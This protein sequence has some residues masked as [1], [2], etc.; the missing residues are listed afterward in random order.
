MQGTEEKVTLSLEE[1]SIPAGHRL[2]RLPGL[3]LVLGVA[4]L[5]LSLAWGRGDLP[6]LFGAYLVAWLFFLTLALGSLVFVLIQFATRAGW[7]VTVRR[8]AEHVMGTLPGLALLGLPLAWG[9]HDLYHW[10]HPEAVAADPVLQGKRP[11]LNE[12]F[13]L[14]RSLVYL[15]SWSAMAW[16]FRR[17]SLRQDELGQPDLTRRLQTL[18]PLGLIW[19]ALTLT[20]AS[21]DWIMSLDPHWYSTIFGVYVFAGAFLSAL[22]FLIVLALF[23]QSAGLVSH[24]VTT[25]HYHD[26]GKLLFGF[27]V[28]WAYIAFSQ[29]MLI[30]YGNIPEETAWYWHRLHHGWGSVSVLLAV[31]H[32]VLPFFFLLPRSVKRRWS[33]LLAAALWVLLMH[34]VDLF[35]LVVPS[36][37][38]DFQV[39]LVYLWTLLGVGGIFLAVLGWLMR[40]RALVPA[41]DPRLEEALSFENM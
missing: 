13:F 24:L 18:S 22:A 4:G 41:R 33:T 36:L 21:F 23:L 28:F 12:G 5:G 37:H 34:Y 2:Q 25:E 29:F 38:Q 7:S 30:W 35:W 8:L 3:G 14:L 1:V 10:T 19:F 39:G 32:F 17:Q 6:G 15:A 16:W 40:R 11:Y 27:V 31:G 26:L 9:V 20:F